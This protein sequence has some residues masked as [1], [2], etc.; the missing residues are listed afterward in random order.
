MPKQKV[1]WGCIECGHLQPKWSGQCPSCENW[2]SLKE[3]SPLELEPRRF[4]TQ[5]AQTIKPVKLNEVV[6]LESDRLKSN[7]P[8]FDRLLG[9]GVVKGSLTLLGGD[10]GIGKSTLLLQTLSGF[11]T[12]NKTVLYVCG[13]ESIHQVSLR[14]KRLNIEADQLLLLAETDFVRI[15]KQIELI[16]PDLVVVD[17]IQVIYK[18]DLPSLPGSV[19]QIREC[20]TELMY[21]AKNLEISIFVIGHVTKSGEIAG[22]KILEH[23]VDTVLYF[24]GDRQHHFRILRVVKNRFG[25]CDEIGI[26]QMLE[27]GLKEVQNPSEIFLEQYQESRVGSAIIPTVEGSCPIL[28]EAQALVTPL[29]YSTPTRKSMGVDQN[30]LAL[31]IA[32]LDKKVGLS[33]QRFDVFL[34]LAGGIKV[35]ETA[36][37]LGLIMALLSSYKDAALPEKTVFIAEVGLSGNL[38]RVSRIAKRLKEA[39]RMGFQKAYIPKGNL[40]DCSKELLQAISIHAMEN[41]HDVI[42]SC[43]PEE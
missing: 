7:A 40:K 1:I 42:Q 26:Y 21:L 18:S 43:L 32:V 15:K 16:Q 4:D 25:P 12:Q 29:A 38:R 34:A 11:V 27:A 8:A 2:N 20:T 3:E 28:V 41:V 10:P 31:L 33:L 24:E 5:T 30:R 19:A 37:D 39:E 36:T 6:A 13:E 14:A 22:P 17:S 9:G 23:L 35:S